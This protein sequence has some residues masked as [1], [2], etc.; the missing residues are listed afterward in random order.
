MTIDKLRQEFDSNIRNHF[1]KSHP[2]CHYCNKPAEHVHHIIPLSKG[3]DNRENNLIALCTECHGLIHNINFKHKEELK[4]RQ[5]EGI[6]RAQK[7]GKFRGGQIKRLKKDVYFDNKDKYNHRL[8]TKCQF[9]LNIG[10]SR[11]TLDRI[12]K[13]EQEYIEV[14]Q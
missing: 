12:L 6:R 4:Q 1:I 7:E 11:P 8:I 3:G 10:V 14:M 13:N 9:A 2:T 5:M